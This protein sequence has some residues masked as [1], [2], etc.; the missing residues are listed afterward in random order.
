MATIYE[1]ATSGLSATHS[2][3]IFCWTVHDL[4]NVPLA[5]RL[6][7]Y[8][9]IVHI[10]RKDENPIHIPTP[11]WNSSTTAWNSDCFM[12][13]WWKHYRTASWSSVHR[14]LQGKFNNVARWWSGVI[15]RILTSSSSRVNDAGS[16]WKTKSLSCCSTC[17]LEANA[18]SY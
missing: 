10:C 17:S 3:A 15:S 5:H 11:C 1:P 2:M 6:T 8:T 9:S 4:R 14:R 7:V 12:K 18:E 16:S 13:T